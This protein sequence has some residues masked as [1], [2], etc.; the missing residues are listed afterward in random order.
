MAAYFM[1]IDIGSSETKGILMDE[2]WK[3]IHTCTAQHVMENPAPHYFEHDAEGV[4]W[5]D[6]CAVSQ[7]LLA[8]T[9][10]SPAEIAGVGA[11]VLGCDCLPVDE[12]CRPLRKAILYGID[13]RCQGEIEWLTEHFGED[14]V[15]ER[16]GH[17][18]CSDD[19]AAKI[20][21][22]KNHEPEVYAKTYK[23]LTGSSYITAKLTGNYVIDQ[24]LAKAAFRPLYREDGSINEAEC[25][26]FC[27][28]DQ[29][30]EPRVVTD[31]AGHV[32]AEAAQLGR[33]LQE[34]DRAARKVITDAGYGKYFIHRTGHGVGI[35]V[36]ETP[37][38]A[39]GET[40]IL[41]PGMAFS[42]EPGIYLLGRFGV[43]IEDL[44]LMTEDGV[45]ILHSYPR[46]LVCY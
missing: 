42:I 43:R 4:W 23:F 33:E 3:P 15:I 19:V 10:I 17:P 39:E 25:G 24:F 14:G 28:P 5:H 36:H 32:T 38:A 29:L 30:C 20:L 8:E 31:L 26:L 12:H 37:N 11:S 27:R 46:E 2:S 16:F 9:G 45:E 21:W 34:V 13:A 40:A 22:V 6:F 35:D 7:A 44:A 18:V 41:K 1:G